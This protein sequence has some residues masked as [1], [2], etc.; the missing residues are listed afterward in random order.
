MEGEETTR[1]DINAKLTQLVGED[2]LFVQCT[3]PEHGEQLVKDW[4]VWPDEAGEIFRGAPE[5]KGEL[6]GGKYV[7][8]ECPLCGSTLGVQI[9]EKG[10]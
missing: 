3:I 6:F 5:F 7:T 1:P 9:R 10:I 4:K 8:S 2:R